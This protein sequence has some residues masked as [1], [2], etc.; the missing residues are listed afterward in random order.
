MKALSVSA[1]SGN[2]ASTSMG[3]QG[4][5][6]IRVAGTWVIDSDNDNDND[7]KEVDMGYNEGPGQR[8]DEEEE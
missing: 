7:D 5:R 1:T 4:Q 8:S 6:G 2:R 3:N